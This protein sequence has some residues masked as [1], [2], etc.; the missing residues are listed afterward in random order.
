LSRYRITEH[1]DPDDDPPNDHF[2]RK[3]HVSN[4]PSS[5]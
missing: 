5:P 1:L 4:A 3:L 2:I